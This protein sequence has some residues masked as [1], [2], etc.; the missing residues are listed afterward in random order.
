M[1][2]LPFLLTLA[3]RR[4]GADDFARRHAI[5]RWRVLGIPFVASLAYNSRRRSPLLIG[6]RSTR[7]DCIIFA[8]GGLF[9]LAG[10]TVSSACGAGKARWAFGDVKFMA[11]A[12]LWLGVGRRCRSFM[13]A[14]RRHRRVCARLTA[15]GYLGRGPVFPFGPALII[16]LLCICLRR[17]RRGIFLVL[18][19]LQ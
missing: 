16:R 19:L 3:S 15:G 1:A 2:A 17:K 14:K 13:I 7:S 8:Y 6:R 18:N 11:V 4:S 9:W 5:H 10:Q 12:G